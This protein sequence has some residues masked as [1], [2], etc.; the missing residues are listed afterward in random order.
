[1][2]NIMPALGTILDIAGKVATTVSTGKAIVD[3]LEGNSNTSNNVVSNP[4]PQTIFK[5]IEKV[6]VIDKPIHCNQVQP[7]PVVVNLNVYVGSDRHV[8]VSSND[9]PICLVERYK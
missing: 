4:Q 6:E 3:T 9:T 7:S 1:M 8:G 2:I 5:P